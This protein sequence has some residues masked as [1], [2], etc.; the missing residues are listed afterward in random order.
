MP[1]LSV[2]LSSLSQMESSWPVTRSTQRNG[3]TIELAKTWCKW[4]P[5]RLSYVKRKITAEKTIIAPT[6]IEEI[7]LTF[8]NE[9]N[10]I[11]QAHEIPDKKIIKQSS[12]LPLSETT[13][14]QKRVRLELLDTSDY[15][16]I[17]GP[18][19]VTMAGGFFQQSS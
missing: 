10:E 8:Y 9:I 12:L 13:H 6:L 1:S 2:V 5:Q 14:S 18:C 4:I 7:S 17:T 11:V 19:G 16:Q 3:G 15:R